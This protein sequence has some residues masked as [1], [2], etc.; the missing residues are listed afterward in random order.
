MTTSARALSLDPRT[1]PIPTGAR[2]I[3]YIRVSTEKQAGEKKVSPET[4]L[5][6]CRG[7]ATERGL[8]VDYVVEDHESGAHLERLDRLYAALQAHRLP[9]GQRGLLVV[10][11]TSRWGRFDKKDGGAGLDQMFRMQF[12]RIGWDVRIGDAPETGHDAADLFVQTGQAIA[13]TEYRTQ[14]RQ[15]VID[16]MPKVAAMGFWQGRAPFGYGL[17]AAEGKRRKLVKGDERAVATVQRIFQRYVG[18]KTLQAIAAELNAEKVPGPFDVYASHTWKFERRSAPCG[19]WT[20]SAVRSILACETYTGKLTFRPREVRDG[21]AVLRFARGHV[22]EQFWVIVEKCHPALIERRTFDAAGRRLADR[23]KPR[24]WSTSEVPYILSGLMTCATCG[25]LVVGGGGTR[26]GAEDPTK[27]RHYRCRNSVGEHATC[28]KPMLTVNQ[29]WIESEVIGRVAVHVR[30]LVTSGELEKL[31]DRRL[32]ASTQR[33]EKDR[34]GRELHSL[35]AQR[36]TL[37]EKVAKGL[38]SDDDAADVLGGIKARLVA[39]GRELEE[40]KVRPTNADKKAERD[41][42]LTQAADFATAIKKAPAPVIREL[43]NY[44]IDGRITLDK[45]GRVATMRLRKVPAVSDSNY[46]GRPDPGRRCWRAVS[47]RSCRA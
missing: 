47:P 34:L 19:R 28:A 9:T 17:I 1:P 33:S 2:C 15:R 31:L 13:A 6:V 12:R 36:R 40:Q 21:G 23:A 24:K 25:G 22:P 38:L 43:L 32:K 5:E 30:D 20:A 46:Q 44:W 16:N 29:R 39:V 10:Y 7:L 8:T 35:E 18:G 26:P 3:A 11:D 14:L 41:R 4:Q 42:L 37:V 27:L 45:T